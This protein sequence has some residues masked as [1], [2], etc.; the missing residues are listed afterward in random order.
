[1]WQR[2]QTLYLLVSIALTGAMFFA[3]KTSS[4]ISFVSY[5]PYLALLIVIALLEL[6]ALST[7]RFRVFQMRTCI[8]CALI[9]LALQ[10]WLAV[11]FF[12]AGPQ[13]IF[14]MTAVFPLVCTILDTL[15]AA[16]IW[17]DEMIVRSS[18]RHRSAKRKSALR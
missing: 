5:W 4:G 7:P 2:I 17:R 10:G 3:P 12:T 18:S 9:T 1:M 15:A 14:R 16:A 8:L 11:D 6:L 13:T